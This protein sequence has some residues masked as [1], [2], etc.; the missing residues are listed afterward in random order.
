[1]L[2]GTGKL[3]WVL[4]DLLLAGKMLCSSSLPAV[5]WYASCRISPMHPA[6]NDSSPLA[7][8]LSM[9]IHNEGGFYVKDETVLRLQLLWSLMLV[10]LEA[11]ALMALNHF[12]ATDGLALLCR[13][14]QELL[15]A[16]RVLRC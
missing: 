4:L 16:V 8:T 5:L 6:P 2:L 12:H 1:M 11:Y 15:H 9:I 3:L 10:H 7:H 14:H 13:Q